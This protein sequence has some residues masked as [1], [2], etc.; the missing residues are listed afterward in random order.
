MG[1]LD[2]LAGLAAALYAL[3]PEDFVA[4]RTDRAKTARAGGARD[5]ACRVGELPKP[6]AAAWLLNQLVR[7]RP[8]EVTHLV[9]LGDQMREAQRTL[10]GDQ[11][12]VLTKQRHAV[13]AAFARQVA[14]LADELDRPL[15]AAVA[16]QVEETLRAAIADEDA[17]RALLSGRLTTALS[18]VGMGEVDVSAAVAVPPARPDRPE[19][20][21]QVELPEP[22][23]ELAAA[24][25][26]RLDVAGRA[27]SEAEQAAGRF[28]TELEEAEERVRRLDTE[29][30]A[31]HARIEELQALLV[32]ATED[33]G[34]V[35][36]R[37]RQARSTRQA[38]TASAAQAQRAVERAQADCDALSDD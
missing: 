35:D 27:L 25:Q 24:R 4:A 19:P 10:A 7:R 34:A 5:L 37:L 23:D 11:L 30:A 3:P 1:D 22:H 36:A 38:A 8:D 26:R 9:E 17:G 21:G 14:S 29:S 6:T 32:D 13:V 15:S 16:T 2:E 18:Y 31:L 28:A 20:R 33:A 12:R